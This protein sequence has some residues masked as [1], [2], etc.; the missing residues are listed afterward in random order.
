MDPL[1]VL[2]I[3]AASAEF[4]D[5]TTNIISNANAIKSRRE[6][7]GLGTIETITHDLVEYNRRFHSCSLLPAS[8]S[9]NPTENN[10]V[11]SH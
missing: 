8:G 6:V 4:Y 3:V 2:S 7:P 11:S 1:T 9:N 5:F 10:I